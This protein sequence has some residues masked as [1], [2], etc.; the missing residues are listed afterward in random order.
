MYD[1]TI[2]MYYGLSCVLIVQSSSSTTIGLELP[3]AGAI[4]IVNGHY[5]LLILSP[6]TAE[7]ATTIKF[8]IIFDMIV[9]GSHEP[10]NHEG[11]ISS[12]NFL[13]G[14]VEAIRAQGMFYLDFL[15]ILVIVYYLFC[16]FY[17]YL[18]VNGIEFILQVVAAQHMLHQQKKR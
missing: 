15:F 16:V 1:L 5:S 12:Q 6:C 8:D 18:V 7:V 11:D 2:D 14:V 4:A 10:M 13:L 17:H 3:F 9:E